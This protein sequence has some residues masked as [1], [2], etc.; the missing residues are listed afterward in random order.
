MAKYDKNQICLI[1]LHATMLNPPL[2]CENGCKSAE[3]DTLGEQFAD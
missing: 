3:F 2:K 1:F